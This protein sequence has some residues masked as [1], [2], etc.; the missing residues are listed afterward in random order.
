MWSNRLEMIE[1]NSDSS[2]LLQKME[3][4]TFTRLPVYD[5]SPPNIIGFVNI[6]E[7]L[8]TGRKFTD[9]GDFTEP[10]R[11]LSADTIIVD[12]INIMRSENQRIVLVTRVGRIGREKPVGVVTMKDLVEELLGEL[13]EW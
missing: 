8:A 4:S 2:V 1:Q 9:L 5:Q 13:S 10:L 3:K 7:V 6:Y 12:A 11:R